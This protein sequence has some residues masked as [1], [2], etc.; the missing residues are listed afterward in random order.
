MSTIQA[1]SVVLAYPLQLIFLA[2]A[3]YLAFKNRYSEAAF[4][5]SFSVMFLLIVRLP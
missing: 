2:R 5:M 3:I 1:I 4:C